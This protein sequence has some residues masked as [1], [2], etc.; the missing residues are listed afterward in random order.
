MNELK[1]YLK[2]PLSLLLR[3]AVTAAAILTVAVLVF[4]ILYIVINLSLI[5][6]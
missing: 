6:I 1:S 4:L 5:H 2:R 3:V